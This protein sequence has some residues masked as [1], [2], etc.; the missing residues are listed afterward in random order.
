MLCGDKDSKKN[1]EIHLGHYVCIN[2]LKNYIREI[3]RGPLILLDFNQIKEKTVTMENLP[4]KLLKCP[5]R[6][7]KFHFGK[8]IIQRIMQ[9]FEYK[10][11][12]RKAIRAAGLKLENEQ[13]VLNQPKWEELKCQICQENLN[14][15]CGLELNCGHGYCKNDLFKFLQIQY[16]DGKGIHGIKCAEP[17]CGQN[18]EIAYILEMLGPEKVAVLEDRSIRQKNKVF[19]CSLCSSEL[20]IPQNLKSTNILCIVCNTTICRL[21]LQKAHNGP[22]EYRVKVFLSL[23]AYFL[24]AKRNVTSSTL[25]ILLAIECKK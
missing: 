23:N 21:C 11:Q 4:F 10:I 19:E 24:D 14:E 1:I 17:G 5:A 3:N 13:K 7:C 2:C 20:I 6:D 9:E 8:E 25:S 18:I 16:N 15:K 22:C 12:V